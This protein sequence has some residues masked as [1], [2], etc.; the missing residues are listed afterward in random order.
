MIPGIVILLLY[1]LGD[2]VLGA[3][4][5]FQIV[6][7]FYVGYGRAGFLGIAICVIAM[8]WIKIRAPLHELYKDMVE[9]DR[10]IRLSFIRFVGAWQET[11][12]TA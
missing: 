7:D 8:I 6:R 4:L 11:L 1:F 12:E 9:A 3:L 5:V 10:R 2:K